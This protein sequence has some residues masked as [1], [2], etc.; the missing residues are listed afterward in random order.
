MKTLIAIYKEDGLLHY[1]I[2]DYDT[3]KHYRED[4]NN[5]GYRVTVIIPENEI[6]EYINSYNCE[7]TKLYKR[8]VNCTKTFDYWERIWQFV[9][10]TI[11]YDYGR[12]IAGIKKEC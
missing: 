12:Q 8:I 10:D 4:L 11:V 5:N 3:M 7:D 9:T 6:I 2:N 1:M